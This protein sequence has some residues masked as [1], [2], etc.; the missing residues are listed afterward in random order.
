MGKIK[1]RKKG[2]I[3]GVVRCFSFS[4]IFSSQ[5]NSCHKNYL[6]YIKK[7]EPEIFCK[8]GEK[9]KRKPSLT[10]VFLSLDKTLSWKNKINLEK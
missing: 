5:I 7:K 6:K 1:R 3:G 8:K 4:F 9:K 2:G 10:Y